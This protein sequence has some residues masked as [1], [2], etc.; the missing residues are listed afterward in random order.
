MCRV[1]SLGSLLGLEATHGRHPHCPLKVTATLNDYPTFISTF[2][3][4]REPGCAGHQLNLTLNLIVATKS[5]RLFVA[6]SPAPL[7]DASRDVKH[8]L[9]AI[10]SVARPTHLQQ[11]ARRASFDRRRLRHDNLPT[12]HSLRTQHEYPQVSLSPII[13]CN[14]LR[15][16]SL[17]YYPLVTTTVLSFP[18]DSPRPRPHRKR[19]PSLRLPTRTSLTS[20]SLATCVLI[21][22]PLGV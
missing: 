22:C 20:N 10:P 8:I 15:P 19:R 18:L 14:L 13:S 7:L 17:L 16:A 1:A 6:G 9:R 2:F 12:N 5:L 11:A 4:G 21:S 3:F